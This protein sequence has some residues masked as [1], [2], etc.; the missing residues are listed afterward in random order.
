MILHWREKKMFH[1]HHEIVNYE[2]MARLSK[3]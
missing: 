2:N 3:E 1:E